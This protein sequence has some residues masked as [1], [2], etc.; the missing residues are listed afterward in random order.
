MTGVLYNIQRFS[1]HDGPGI[2]TTVFF[3]GCNMRCPWC[4][5]PESIAAEPQPMVSFAKCTG[6]GA[7][8]GVCPT[9]AQTA[10]PQRQFDNKKCV[11][12]GECAKACPAGAIKITGREYT[13][14]EVMATL[15]RDR[16]Y[17]QK[18]GG[19]VTFSGGEATL[20]HEFL[21]A[22][23]VAC[24]QDGLH[25][26][27]D[28]NGLVPQQR[29]LRLGEIMDLFLVDFKGM[30][31][32]QGVYGTLQVLNELNRP[33]ILRCPI[34]PGLNDVSQHFDEIKRIKQAYGNIKEVELMPYHSIGAGKWKDVGLEYTL[35]GTLAPTPEQIEAWKAIF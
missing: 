23:A 30:P 1:L 11:L 16:A 6:C 35:H 33:V 22:L 7:C 13:V 21:C 17:Y 18:S 5:N 14:D 8:A 3:K 2:R 27:L 10:L 28:T 4:H 20:Q 26:C 25:T 31:Q 29:L 9:G 24:K 34:I 32:Q 15:R 19:G 12:C